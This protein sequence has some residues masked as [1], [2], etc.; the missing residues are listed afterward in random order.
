MNQI[1]EDIQ[2][3]EEIMDEIKALNEEAR[4]IATQYQKTLREKTGGYN[5]YR[6]W[7]DGIS[8]EVERDPDMLAGHMHRMEDTLE[9]M[10]GL[11]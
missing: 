7:Y 11:R 9:D 5:M 2:R 4:G 10:R 8:N 3:F 6:Y 1:Q